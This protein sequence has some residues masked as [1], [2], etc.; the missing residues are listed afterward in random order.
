MKPI[1]QQRPMCRL[2]QILHEAPALLESFPPAELKN[3]SA[4]CRSLRTSFCAHVKMITLSNPEDAS[5]LCCTTWPQLQMVVSINQR[6]L[7]S[8]LSAQWECMLELEAVI[9]SAVLI[10][11]RQQLHNPLIDLPSQHYAALSAF[12]NK[13]RHEVWITLRGPFVGCCIVHSLTLDAW[14]VLSHL[15]LVDSPQLA[16]ESISHLRDQLSL[17]GLYVV[18]CF[19][20]AAVLL[21][22]TTG[23]HQLQR[24]RLENNQLDDTAMSVIGQANWPNLRQLSL[25]CNTLGVVGMQHLVSCSLPLLQRLTLEHTGI[26]GPAVQ[27]L[28]QGQ[29]P[30]LIYL[31]LDGNHVDPRGVSYLVQG[32]WPLLN[33][34]TLSPDG[35]DATAAS[36]LG[37]GEQWGAAIAATQQPDTSHHRR[38]HSNV[39]TTCL[40]QFQRLRLQIFTS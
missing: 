13:H 23:W 5:K 14:P 38:R 24:I 3:L 12:A 21:K 18:D 17:T 31:S 11:P 33:L 2:L 34:L 39:Y 16:P 40:P 15:M 25:N 26:D 1:N 32:S 7:K 27:C 20:N 36:L 8:K 35:L 10:R 29:W 22:L 9:K 28:A 37:I 6:D 30:A 19:L 4:T